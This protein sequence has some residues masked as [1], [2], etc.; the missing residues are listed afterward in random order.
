VGARGIESGA[1][2]SERNRSDVDAGYVEA[3]HG[4]LEPL[5]LLAQQV[6]ARNPYALEGDPAERVAELAEL[7]FGRPDCHPW[8]VAL[9]H[10][11]GH[12]ACAQRVIEGAEDHE[13]VGDGS[14]GYR[15]L[16]AVE[17]VAIA[18]TARRRRQ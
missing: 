18:V 2:E 17:H 5:S 6:L 11:H 9:D 12:A 3:G 10:E 15:P 1:G 16:R 8:S 4:D 14:E 13:G 7:P